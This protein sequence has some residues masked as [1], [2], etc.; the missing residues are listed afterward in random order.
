MSHLDTISNLKYWLMLNRLPGPKPL[1]LLKWLRFYGSPESVLNAPGEQLKQ[2][3]ASP[4]TLSLIQDLQ[5]LKDRSNLA[6]GAQ[7]DLNWVHGL[8]NR[9]L[10]CLSHS[11]YPS[12]LKAIDDPPLVL[13]LEGTLSTIQSPQLA[14]VGSR[15]ASP[16]GLNVAQTLASEIAKHWVVTSGLALGID[17][18]AHRGAIETGETIAV[19]GCGLDQ[20]Y[21]KRHQ[22]LAQL[23]RNQGL[24]IS[25][26]PIGV[27]P[28]SHH[29]PRR[30][31][32]ISGMSRGVVVVE[33]GLKSG[34]LIT[35]QMALDQNREVFAVPGHIANPQTQGCHQLIQQG[36]K[37]VTCA[38][39]IFSEFQDI[40]LTDA[41]KPA[42]V[43]LPILNPQSEQILKAIDFSPTSSDLIS[44]R[45]QQ[46]VHEITSALLELELE[47]LIN[48][49][50]GGFVRV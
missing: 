25:E 42:P 38:E 45:V 30:N 5:T 44:E 48:R 11:Q 29:F 46:K 43:Q 14:F 15:N 17:G 33:A 47:G 37:L 6:Q 39:D 24:L 26:F 10:L 13:F 4:S 27:V 40:T 35:A 8:K 41:V 20:I 18:A 21:P 16:G 12:L 2:A 34:T 22:G 49:C 50:P 31:R 7:R 1:Q 32:I 9:A 36:A 19:L 3:G 23:V 28:R